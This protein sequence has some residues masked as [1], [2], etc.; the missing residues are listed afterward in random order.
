[1]FDTDQ[2]Q[3]VEGSTK[4]MSPKQID[5]IARLY[6]VMSPNVPFSLKGFMNASEQPNFGRLFFANTYAVSD[7]TIVGMTSFAYINWGPKTK[8][9][10]EDVVVLPAFRGHGIASILLTEA[11]KKAKEVG[12][13]FVELTSSDEKEAAHGLYRKFGF[14]NPET[15]LFR[16]YLNQ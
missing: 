9:Y 12:C 14:I 2:L 5:D 6:S 15:N 8:G 3:F 7:P 13:A 10:V 4:N 11:I 16:L 1:M